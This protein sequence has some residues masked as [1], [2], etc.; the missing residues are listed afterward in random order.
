MGFSPLYSDY[1]QL[2]QSSDYKQLNQSSD[3]KQLNQS[4]DYKQL[5]QSFE[6]CYTVLC[7]RI[8]TPKELGQAWK[9]WK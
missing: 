9:S 4:S 2:N 7:V 6:I 8:G 5:N 1:K 3:Y